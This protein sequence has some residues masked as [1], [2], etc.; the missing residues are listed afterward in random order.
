MAQPPGPPEMA[1]DRLNAHLADYFV[2]DVRTA[3][4]DLLL[5]HIPGA[6]RLG[7]SDILAK[8]SKE[9]PVVVACLSGHRSVPMAAWLLQQGYREVYNLT[10]GFLAWKSAG[11]R[12]ER[13]SS[14]QPKVP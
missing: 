11:Y 6:T 14:T 1:P 4:E 5:G 2:L 12:I 3:A 8:I 10:G 13:G 7:K 9:T